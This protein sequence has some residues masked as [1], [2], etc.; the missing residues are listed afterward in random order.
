MKR[1]VLEWILEDRLIFGEWLYAAIRC[2]IAAAHYFF[3]FDIYDKRTEDF[4]A[5]DLR[6]AHA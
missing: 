2:T 3:E 6:L 5:L 4:L 1:P